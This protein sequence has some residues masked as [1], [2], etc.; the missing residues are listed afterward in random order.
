MSG[1]PSKCC[2]TEFFEAVRCDDSCFKRESVYI[3][4]DEFDGKAADIEYVRFGTDDDGDDLCWY[5]DRSQTP[6]SAPAGATIMSGLNDA[7]DFFNSEDGILIESGTQDDKLWVVVADCRRTDYDVILKG[8]SEPPYLVND[9]TK[10][11]NFRK[12]FGSSTSDVSGTCLIPRQQFFAFNSRTATIDGSTA[13]Q[14]NAGAGD[15]APLAVGQFIQLTGNLVDISG[16]A[17][18]VYKTTVGNNA[19]ETGLATSTITNGIFKVIDIKRQTK[20]DTTGLKYFRDMAAYITTPTIVTLDGDCSDCL[21]AYLDYEGQSGA[22]DATFDTI[23]PFSQADNATWGAD[24]IN[25]SPLTWPCRVNINRTF[26]IRCDKTNVSGSEINKMRSR[27]LL[28]QDDPFGVT[29]LSTNCDNPDD[30]EQVQLG[31]FGFCYNQTAVNDPIPCPNSIFNEHRKGAGSFETITINTEYTRNVRMVNDNLEPVPT[32]CGSSVKLSSP[33]SE[34][35]IVDFDYLLNSVSITSTGSDGLTGDDLIIAVF[36]TTETTAA[37]EVSVLP[38]WQD[39]QSSRCGT[40]NLC[41]PEG[42][43]FPTGSLGWNDFSDKPVVKDKFEAETPTI[44]LDYVNKVYHGRI[45]FITKTNKI[46]PMLR[47]SNFYCAEPRKTEQNQNPIPD[48]LG[49]Q[50]AI[51]ADAARLGSPIDLVVPLAPQVEIAAGFNVN[52]FIPSHQRTAT[53]ADGG[54]TDAVTDPTDGTERCY[55]GKSH[56]AKI[57]FGSAGADGKDITSLPFFLQSYCAGED[58]YTYVPGTYACVSGNDDDIADYEALKNCNDSNVNSKKTNCPKFDSPDDCTAGTPNNCRDI[59]ILTNPGPFAFISPNNKKTKFNG[60]QTGVD[61]TV[62]SHNY[63]GNG[64]N[65]TNGGLSGDKY[66]FINTS[67]FNEDSESNSNVKRIGVDSEWSSVFIEAQDPYA[68]GCEG[69]M[70]TV[71]SEDNYQ[72]PFEND[73]PDTVSQ[74]DPSS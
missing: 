9:A 35:D 72:I 66:E 14:G 36:P 31:S 34:G 2:T 21:Q 12:R 43:T 17:A 65:Y 63:G 28:I 51:D 57:T 50:Q 11:E 67:T 54:R 27:D 42:N 39:S 13:H 70:R 4:V 49:I 53:V 10:A 15:P 18:A 48:V 74:I 5:V 62:T 69:C 33:T 55:P 44:G 6:G 41:F 29:A 61:F 58:S 16:S 24:L 46:I 25:D 73:D 45:G 38:G 19:A 3:D 30:N 26:D 22:T 71:F 32:G 8:G 47:Y 68:R 59:H 1:V 52:G 23:I 20:P 7:T 37:L 64:R 40:F 60:S 56:Q